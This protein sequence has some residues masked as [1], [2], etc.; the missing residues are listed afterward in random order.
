MID[1]IL[2]LVIAGAF[3]LGFKAGNTFNTLGDLAQA[4]IDKLKN[5]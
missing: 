2:V 3:L 5:N 4:G 1:L